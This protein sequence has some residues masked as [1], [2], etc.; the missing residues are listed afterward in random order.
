MRASDA[1]E[2]R[3]LPLEPGWERLNWGRGR[4]QAGV[5]ERVALVSA[6][7]AAGTLSSEARA[8]GA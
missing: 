3:E 2:G 5:L 1:C 8:G 4:L 7:E 6:W